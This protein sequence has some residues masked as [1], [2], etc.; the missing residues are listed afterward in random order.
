[1]ALHETSMKAT[2]EP[3][4]QQAKIWMLAEEVNPRI[5]KDYKNWLKSMF[6]KRKYSF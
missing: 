2:S 6:D 1:M 5:I 4:L 3:H